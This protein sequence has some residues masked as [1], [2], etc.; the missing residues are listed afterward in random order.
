MIIKRTTLVLN[1]LRRYYGPVLLLALSILTT[2]LFALWMGF[3]LSM[4]DEAPFGNDKDTIFERW[5]LFQSIDNM[6]NRPDELGYSP[7]YFDEENTFGYTTATYGISLVALPVYILSGENLDLAYNFYVMATFPLTALAA[8]VLMRYLLGVQPWVAIAPA[9]MVAFTAHSFSHITHN[10]Q[11]S[12][13][14]YLLVLIFFHKVIDSPKWYWALGLTLSAWLVFMSSGYLGMMSVSTCGIIFIYLAVKR[15]ITWRLVGLLAVA[16]ALAGALLLPFITFRLAIPAFREGQTY[17]AMVSDANVLI[18]SKALIY[19]GLKTS[20]GE[21]ALFLGIVP[22]LIAVLVWFMR[23][24]VDDQPAEGRAFSQ[25]D[26]L[27]LYGLVMLGGFILAL[28]PEFRVD[29]RTLFPLPYA[30]LRHLPGYNGMRA[31]GRFVVMPIT[32]SSVLAA[33]W[34]AYYVKNTRRT[35]YVAVLTVLLVVSIAERIPTNTNGPARHEILNSFTRPLEDRFSWPDPIDRT[36]PVTIWLSEQPPNTA[37]LHLPINLESRYRVFD[38]L[39]IHQQPIVNGMSTFFP[40]WYK[41]VEQLD[42][43]NQALVDLMCSRGVEYVFVHYGYLGRGEKGAQRQRIAD[44]MA[45]SD[46]LELVDTM[47]DVEL[48]HITSSCQQFV[49]IDFSVPVPGEGW[50]RPQ[51]H[52]ASF[53][54]FAWT[55]ETRVTVEITDPV[56]TPGVLEFTVFRR[57]SQEIL[58]SLRVSI[59]GVELDLRRRRTNFSAEIPPELIPD[60]GPLE[61]VFETDEVQSPADVSDS[62]DDRTLGVALSRLVIRAPE[63]TALEQASR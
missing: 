13:Q 41:I 19:S 18:S 1:R 8:Y 35:I 28:G 56:P 22:T 4:I 7:I 61:I 34:L 32:G 47:R 62:T 24:K 37:S 11:L 51:R 44:F 46:Q 38:G 6:F 17:R 53:T 20:V 57:A 3:D 30:I 21:D 27:Y 42:F 12:I 26:V 45:I 14:T 58:Q 9:M 39:P 15:K 43:P 63:S 25:R 55:G 52:T 49:S 5:V 31:L 23:K 36:D 29:G 54:S 40:E 2:M 59:D 48:Y 50:Q 10:H 33:I 60:D 16:G